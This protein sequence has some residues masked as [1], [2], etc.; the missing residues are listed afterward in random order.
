[1][2][3]T[4]NKFHEVWQKLSENGSISGNELIAFFEKKGQD[5]E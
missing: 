5:K 4:Q 1:M 2:N 3:N